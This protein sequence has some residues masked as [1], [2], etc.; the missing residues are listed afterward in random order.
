MSVEKFENHPFGDK[1]STSCMFKLIKNVHSEPKTYTKYSQSQRSH[2]GRT[3]DFKPHGH[4]GGFGGDHAHHVCHGVAL[5]DGEDEGG[6]LEL[7]RSHVGRQFCFG[8]PLNVQATGG[9]LLGASV[10]DGFNL[11]ERGA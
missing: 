6:L 4:I 1:S 5:H 8:N 2:R 10:V 7:Q 9:G 3:C 11:R